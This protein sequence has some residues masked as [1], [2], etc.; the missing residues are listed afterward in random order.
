MSMSTSTVAAYARIYKLNRPFYASEFDLN[1]GVMNALACKRLVRETGNKKSEFYPVGGDL[2]RKCEV[3]EWMPV[4]D[5]YSVR[6]LE[7]EIETMRKAVKAYDESF[8]RGY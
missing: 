4:Y 2:Y 3:K 6:R 7:R 5:K 1:G 8:G